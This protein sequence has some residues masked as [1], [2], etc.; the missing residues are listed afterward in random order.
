[1]NPYNWQDHIHDKNRPENLDFLRRFRA[2]LDEYPGST[3]VGEVGDSQRGM[4][5]Q[6]QYTSGGDKVHMCYSFEFLS[7]PRPD[8]PQIAAALQRF[9]A[10]GGDGWACWAFSNHDVMRH[11]SRWG[12]DE[13]AQR[14]HLALLLSLRGSVCL[15]QGEELGLGE[16]EL[17]FAD[18]RDPYGIRFWPKFR[19]RDGCR[20]PMVWEAD[21]PNGGFSRAMPWL[22]VARE[23]LAHAADAQADDPGSMLAFYRR[24]LAFRHRHPVL[25]RGA[26]EVVEARAGYLALIRALDRERMFCAFNLSGTGQ[27]M[28]LPPGDWRDAAAPFNAPQGGML[29]PWQA[30]FA[31]EMAR[32]SV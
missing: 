28:T 30:H 3:A 31:H 4:E 9:E 23:H 20:T 16:A 13:P 22:P 27:A 10:V 2:L 18:L 17:D 14:L 19:G 11:A 29:G 21:A 12:L 6:A 8:A 5:I 26:L 32:G 7:G 1:V 24:M 15:Y 25:A